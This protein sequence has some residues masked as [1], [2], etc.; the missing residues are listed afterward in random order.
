MH[1]G[2][3]LFGSSPG[4]AGKAQTTLKCSNL[5]AIGRTHFPLL[6]VSVCGPCLFSV[7]YNETAKSVTSCRNVIAKEDPTAQAATMDGAAEDSPV[8]LGVITDI[9]YANKADTLIHVREPNPFFVL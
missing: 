2:K 5:Q 8:C 9:Q 3:S 1:L 4:V 7:L 6:D